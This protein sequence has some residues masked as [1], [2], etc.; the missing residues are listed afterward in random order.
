[1]TRFQRPSVAL[2]LATV[3][4]CTLAL[5]VWAHAELV[6]SEPAAGA[7][8]PSG[9]RQ[10]SLTFNEDLSPGSQLVVYA[11]QFAPVPGVTS[12]VDGPVLRAEF[13][14]ALREGVYTVQ[15]TAVGSDGHPVAGSYQFAIAPPFGAGLG[16]R[17]IFY[18]TFIVGFLALGA[19]LLLAR[20]RRK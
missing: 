1:M 9:L 7:T 3:L 17:I 8:V 18:T 16:P 11:D 19:V 14:A 4:A 6:S 5:P 12:T 13:A 20:R 10:L 15:W 2:L